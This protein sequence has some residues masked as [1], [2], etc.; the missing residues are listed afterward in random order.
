MDKKQFVS[1]FF[2]NKPQFIASN[3]PIVT[4]SVIPINLSSNSSYSTLELISTV[5]TATFSE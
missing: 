4:P 2:I 5:W 3:T 1:A